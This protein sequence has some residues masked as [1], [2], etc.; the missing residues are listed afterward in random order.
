MVAMVMLMVMMT[1]IMNDGGDN[2]DEND[3]DDDGGVGDGDDDRSDNDND[4]FFK[5]WSIFCILVG[6]LSPYN[7]FLDI[8]SP[9]IEDSVKKF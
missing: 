9:Q 5:Y 2:G 8:K 3:G 6:L 1:V 7:K 4:F